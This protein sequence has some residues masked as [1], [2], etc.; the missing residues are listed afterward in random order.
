MKNNLKPWQYDIII[1]L[2]IAVFSML[3]LGFIYLLL[4]D[5]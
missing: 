3:S 2:L 5:L 4:F 1:L